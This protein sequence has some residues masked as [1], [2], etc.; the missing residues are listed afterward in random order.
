[1]LSVVAVPKARE[2]WRGA[3]KACFA[4]EFVR[5]AHLHGQRLACCVLIRG[6][7]PNRSSIRLADWEH[8]HAIILRPVV[9]RS[10][11]CW[12]GMA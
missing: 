6:G 11:C 12:I 1:M 3:S 8:S 5:L 7:F 2:G 4:F 9:R 10:G